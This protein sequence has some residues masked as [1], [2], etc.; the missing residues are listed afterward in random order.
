M[1]YDEFLAERIERV[2]HD[3][4]IPFY[5]K[6]MFGGICYMIDEKMCVGV[7]KKELMVR[8]DPADHQDACAKPGAKPMDFTGASMKGFVMVDPEHVDLDE[9]LERWID[10]AY[11]FNPRAKSS[12][13]K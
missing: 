8:I 4:N 2:L 9:D 13:K 5:G 10:K 3:K 7:L 12:R 1:A 11:D 6:K